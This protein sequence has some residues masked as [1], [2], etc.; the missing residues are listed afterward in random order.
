[1]DDGH[2]AGRRSRS[3]FGG[4]RTC[5]REPQ[6]RPPAETM[7]LRSDAASMNARLVPTRFLKRGSRQVA[8]GGTLPPLPVEGCHGLTSPQ[9]R[10]SCCP[11]RRYGLAEVRRLS[12]PSLSLSTLAFM[13][14]FRQNSTGLPETTYVSSAGMADELTMPR[15]TS[16][17]VRFAGTAGWCR[18]PVRR[19]G[20]AA[21]D[22]HSDALGSTPTIPVTPDDQPAKSTR[23]RSGSPVDGPAG[24]R[25]FLHR[26]RSSLHR[27]QKTV[28]TRSGR[29]RRPGFA[30]L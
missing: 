11:S 25:R 14:D 4:P 28:Q 20:T 16:S 15:T 9:P 17:T 18:R 5:H 22:H 26:T 6:E 27:H 3:A 24:L 30:T 19:R 23:T 21:D 7:Q 12:S 1:M 8:R 29:A 2:R 13:P 10:G